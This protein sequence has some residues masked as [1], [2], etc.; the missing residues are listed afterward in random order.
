MYVI[1][2]HYIYCSVDQLG[3]VLR[4]AIEQEVKLKY[5]LVL[6]GVDFEINQVHVLHMRLALI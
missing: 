5:E 2:K 6:P 4:T 3:E 1:L